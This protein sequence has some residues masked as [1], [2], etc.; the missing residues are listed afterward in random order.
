MADRRKPVSLRAVIQRLNR[1]LAHTGETLKTLRGERYLHD[2]G[3]YFI[4]NNATNTVDTTD[5]DPV[6]LARE[7]GVL[8]AWETV[9]DDD[10]ADERRPA[11]LRERCAS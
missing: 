5:V 10:R 4:V 3:R 2:F 9:E 8:A 7:L 1:K 11:A 6:A